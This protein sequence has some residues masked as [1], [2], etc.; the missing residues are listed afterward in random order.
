MIP[1]R[2]ANTPSAEG[3]LAG[4]ERITSSIGPAIQP[5][6][7]FSN[8]NNATMTNVKGPRTN[9][10]ATQASVSIIEA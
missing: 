5:G 4:L 7:P 2:R 9:L 10:K 1:A 6:G 3:V 8:A